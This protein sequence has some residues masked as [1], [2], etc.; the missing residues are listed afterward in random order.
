MNLTKNCRKRIRIDVSSS[1]AEHE[2]RLSPVTVNALSLDDA[3]SPSWEEKETAF[4]A[5][6]AHLRKTIG[7]GHSRE[8]VSVEMCYFSLVTSIMFFNHCTHII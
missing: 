1:G 7:E 5:E 2:E 4:R 3:E 8:K 6:I